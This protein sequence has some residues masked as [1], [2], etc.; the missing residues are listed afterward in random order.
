MVD[1]RL[2]KI[3]GVNCPESIKFLDVQ[4]Y[5]RDDIINSSIYITIYG[6]GMWRRLEGTGDSIG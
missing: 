4:R 1:V 3:A 6:G 2:A 5:T